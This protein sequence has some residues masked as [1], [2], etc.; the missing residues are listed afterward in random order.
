MFTNKSIFPLSKMMDM[1]DRCPV[2]NQKFELE[3]GF[4]YG[5]GYVSYALSIAVFVVNLIWYK[6][7]FGL[8][9]EDNSIYYYLATS[10]TIVIAIQPW[11]MRLSRSLYLSMF[12]KYGQGTTMKSEE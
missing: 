2:C 6:L 10:I 9:F 3:V 5:T 4:Y 7:I 11:L 8:T 1:P 12:V